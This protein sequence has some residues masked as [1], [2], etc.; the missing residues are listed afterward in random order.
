MSTPLLLSKT[1]RSVRPLEIA[2]D[3]VFDYVKAVAGP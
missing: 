2:L 3:S 1:S